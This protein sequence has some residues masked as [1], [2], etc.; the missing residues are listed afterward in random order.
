M[1]KTY[2]LKHILM[3]LTALL[4][5]TF[6]LADAESGRVQIKPSVSGNTSAKTGDARKLVGRVFQWQV[7]YQEDGAQIRPENPSDYRIHFAAIDRISLN[8][9]CNQYAAPVRLTHSVF[10][11]S[12]QMIGTR[13]LCSRDSLEQEFIRGIRATTG[14]HFSDDGELILTQPHDTGAMHFQEVTEELK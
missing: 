1:L 13:A 8:A 14:W 11:V 3:A 7:T 10:S 6:S 9:D 4:A 5:S 2:L 12:E